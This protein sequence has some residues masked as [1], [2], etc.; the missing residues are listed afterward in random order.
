MF[1]VKHTICQN[2]IIYIN[3][4]KMDTTFHQSDCAL[5]PKQDSENTDF[6][7]FFFQASIRMSAFSYCCQVELLSTKSSADDELCNMII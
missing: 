4:A 6:L 7:M 3:I 1:I 5:C 2:S